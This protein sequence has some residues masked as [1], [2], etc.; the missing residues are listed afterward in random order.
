MMRR[1][2]FTLFELLVVLVIMSLMTA[3][4]AP[5]LVNSL[6][7]LGAKTSAQKV[8]AALRMLRSKAATE[9][10]TYLAVFQMEKRQYFFK[11]PDSAFF[12][13]T[14]PESE[15]P[16]ERFSLSEGVRFEKGVPVQGDVVTSGEF[17]IAFFA[18]GGSSG[19]TVVLS[20]ENDR[21]F[22]VSTD[23]I[24]GAVKVSEAE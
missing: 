3:L 5:R 1:G 22:S 24:T 2:G 21:R 9:K 13:A 10:K 23:L 15:G 4:A 14:Q 19:G 7:R 17:L 8:S 12:G 6:S 11:K 18:S 16:L 20:G